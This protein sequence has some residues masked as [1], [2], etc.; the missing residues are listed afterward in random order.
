M[1]NTIRKLSF[2]ATI[3]FGLQATNAMSI[4]KTEEVKS[5]AVEISFN[6]VIIDDDGTVT[7]DFKTVSCEKPLGDGRI[8]RTEGG[9]WLCSTAA[10][11]R[12]CQDN[13]NRLSANMQSLEPCIC[14][15]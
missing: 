8:L 13:L 15:D 10:A 14:N 7:L 6:N 9:C 5:T 2:V 12:R 11:E 3:L 4:D 1:K